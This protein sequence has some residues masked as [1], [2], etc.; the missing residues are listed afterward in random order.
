M[1]RIF[2]AFVAAFVAILTPGKLISVDFL[3]VK[4]FEEGFGTEE[5]LS[6][7]DKNTLWNVINA[8]RRRTG[9]PS[10]AFGKLRDVTKSLAAFMADQ[11][12]RM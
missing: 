5:P 10:S 6:D 9:G 3:R 4:F 12:H 8:R 2:A 1:P 7:D 11:L